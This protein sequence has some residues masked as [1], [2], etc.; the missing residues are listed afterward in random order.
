M[1]EL[2]VVSNLDC[3]RQNRF[4]SLETSNQGNKIIQT[5]NSSVSTDWGQEEKISRQPDKSNP[6]QI[7]EALT[8]LNEKLAQ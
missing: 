1:T 8:L 6:R 5:N 2:D 4:R 7:K 3:S